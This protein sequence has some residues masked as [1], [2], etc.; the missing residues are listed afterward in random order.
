MVGQGY[1]TWHFL[2]ASASTCPSCLFTV[3][4][5][6]KHPV[7]KPLSDLKVAVK[8]VVVVVVLIYVK[9]SGIIIGVSIVR[10]GVCVFRCS[11]CSFCNTVKLAGSYL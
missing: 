9:C 8:Q 1:S 6:R 10:E 4:P 2:F 11:F 5:G 3:S 7:I